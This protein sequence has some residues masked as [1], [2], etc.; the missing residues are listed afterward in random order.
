MYYK[1]SI[2]V[3][4]IFILLCLLGITYIL[5]TNIKG[6]EK[7]VN[8]TYDTSLV[9]RFPPAN[10]SITI[11]T[12][13]IN[14]NATDTCGLI[15]LTSETL[16]ANS[17][18]LYYITSS[19]NQINSIQ[20]SSIFNSTST[21]NI[22]LI[23]NSSAPAR[24]LT[25][26]SGSLSGHYIIF[27]Y[28]TQLK[29]TNIS[30]TF[31]NAGTNYANKV[32][33]YVVNSTVANSYNIINTTETITGNTVTKTILD[34]DQPFVLSKLIIFFD[35]SL[36]NFNINKININGIPINVANTVQQTANTSDSATSYDTNGTP[37]PGM[38]NPVTIDN[39][40]YSNTSP[41]I[42]FNQ[43]VKTKLPYAMYFAGNID[44]PNGNGIY[45]MQDVYNRSCKN[46]TITGTYSNVI[47]VAPSNSSGN[48]KY[49]TGNVKT[50]I[51]FPYQSIPKE[52]TICAITKYTNPNTNRQ[53]ILSANTYPNNGPNWLLG[54]WGSRTKIA[55]NDGW[56]SKMGAPDNNTSWVISCATTGTATSKAYLFLNDDKY[57][58]NY[59][60]INNYN[61]NSTGTLTINSNP[62]GENSDFALSY[63]IIWDS[64]LLKPELQ[65]VYDALKNYLNTGEELN[66]GVPSSTLSTLQP[67]GSCGNP[68]KSAKEIKTA[69]GTNIDGIYWIKMANNAVKPVYCIMND[70]CNGGGWMLAMKGAKNSN[71]FMF[72][73]T[74][75]TTNSVLNEYNLTRNDGTNNADAKYDVFNQCLINDCLAIFN[76]IDVKNN[77]NLPG[78]GYC[79]YEQNVIKNAQSLLTYFSN[80]NTYINFFGDAAEPYTN[81]NNTPTCESYRYA[82]PTVANKSKTF[83]DK[84]TARNQFMADHITNKYKEGIW[85][86]QREFMAYGLNIRPRTS[87]GHS[88]RWGGTFNENPGTGQWWTGDGSNDVSGGIGMAFNYSCGDYIGCCQYSTGVNASMRF[89]WYVR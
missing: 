29:F 9:V 59:N 54:H 45:Q 78:Y 82:Y 79:W 20:I 13:S 2:I 50:Q 66:Y 34:T 12:N 68:G 36:T 69:T 15:I 48:I 57:E 27:T 49:I 3:L 4:I 30:I 18:D 44:F 11:S 55:Y 80:N 25:T 62:W 43:L 33:L 39:Y 87:W 64:A 61:G 1:I 6:I 46:A 8:Q 73:S 83:A 21:T 7:F 26:S 19:Y 40:S 70:A 47:D 22:N 32:N 74:H 5:T 86:N 81:Y 37:L 75:W 72:N 24:S 67:L 76:P 35:N 31:S 53:R 89:E 10:A 23:N 58:N 71:T 52:Y 63:L 17:S 65:N 38:A 56:I 51:I 42:M 16:V 14:T 41:N 84:E 77:T 85:S 60:P 28:L 88:I